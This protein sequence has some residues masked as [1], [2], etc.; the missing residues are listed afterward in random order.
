MHPSK[1]ESFVGKTSPSSWKHCPGTERV[2]CGG[3]ND[4]IQEGDKH[5]SV[6]LLW[7]MLTFIQVILRL[8]V[9]VAAALTLWLEDWQ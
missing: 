7:H 5:V 2:L 1:L 8:P 3:K 9:P 4:R 6:Q